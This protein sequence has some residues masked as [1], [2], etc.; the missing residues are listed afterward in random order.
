MLF[1]ATF[2]NS[3]FHIKFNIKPVFSDHLSYVTI[4]QW[5]HKTGLTVHYFQ[6]I[7]KTDLMEDKIRT[8]LTTNYHIQ[9]YMSKN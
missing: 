8:P 7:E 9:F 4:F 3:T 2:N 5:S 6:L 1:N